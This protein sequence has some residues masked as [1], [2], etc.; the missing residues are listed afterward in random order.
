MKTQKYETCNNW[1]KKK[2]FSTRNKLSYIKIF[3]ENLLAIE[4]IKTQIIM[5]KPAYL[6]LSILELSEIVMFEFWYNYVKPKYG[7]K[8]KLWIQA[9]SLYT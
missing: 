9:V 4:M 1:K 3:L 2:L 8:A 7:E 6:S 5:N